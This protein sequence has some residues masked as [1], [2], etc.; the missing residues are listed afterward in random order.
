[1]SVDKMSR[2]FDLIGSGE[3]LVA[4]VDMNEEPAEEIASRI[5]ETNKNVKSV[6]VKT[7]GRKGEFRQLGLKLIAGD[8]DTEVLHKEYGYFLR[9]DPQKV[10]FSPRESTERQRMA[11]QVK[12]GETILVMFGGIC[13]YSIAMAKKRPKVEK[14]YSVELN[15]DGHKYA[16]DN[17]RMNKLSHKV[18]PIVG[19]VKKV[20]KGLYGKCDRVVMPLPLGA[21]EFLDTAVKCLKSGGGIINFYSI[22]NEE[23]L[24]TKALE[25][26]GKEL[27]KIKRSYTIMNK[28]PVLPYAPR[29][30][31]IR[32]DIKVK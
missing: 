13:A 29:Q 10:Y 16:L 26:I 12:D 8:K 20:C 23:D 18:V 7:S 30:M 6:L 17:V 3:K 27:K 21:G 5:T 2:S 1:M 32:I 31:K 28:K 14:I 4:I 22:G 11:E 25:T 19:D 9:V 24:F 15:P